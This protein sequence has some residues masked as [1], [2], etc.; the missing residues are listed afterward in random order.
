[1]VN[2]SETK[3][4]YKG[5]GETK[6]FPYT[7]AAID[8]DTIKVAVYDETSGVESTLTNDYY[9]D[10]TA[11]TVTY[12]GYAPGQEPAESQR[13][14]VLKE[15][16]KLVIYR[17]TPLDQRQDLGEKYPLPIIESIGDKLTLIVQELKETMGR[18]IKI[19]ISSNETAEQL[20]ERIFTA[21]KTASEM[22]KNASTSAG[23]AAASEKAA[24][25]SEENAGAS[26][27][28]AAE[29]LENI[30]AAAIT[31]GGIAT[32]YSSI[33]TY[34][35]TAQVM[36]PDGTTYRCIA[37]STGE[38]PPMSGK[39]VQTSMSTQDTFERDLNDDLMPTEYAKATRLWAIDAEEDIFPAENAG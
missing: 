29:I 7:F 25:S 3:V 19:D 38:Y 5:D 11:K 9:V 13:P 33:K 36:L 35:P 21:E 10:T 14:G 34:G 26:E 12:P 23:N 6:V 31:V 30:E 18:T 32:V 28:N 15:T 17:E 24:R 20:K 37:Q 8:A 4:I 16:Q 22:A 2:N 1:M 27:K 39:W